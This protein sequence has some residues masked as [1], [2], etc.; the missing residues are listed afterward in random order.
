MSRDGKGDELLY[1]DYVDVEIHKTHEKQT[2]RFPFEGWVRMSRQDKKT[3]Q[4]KA[5][6]GKKNSVVVYPN[7]K[8][9]FEYRIRVSP[10]LNFKTVYTVRIN[11]DLKKQNNYNDYKIEFL[12]EL[13]K[14]GNL[15]LCIHGIY[16]QSEIFKF[17]NDTEPVDIENKSTF[18]IKCKEIGEVSK[19]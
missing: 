3:E 10:Q 7:D 13:P 8:P 18:Q 11:Y 12:S 16:G 15:M 17:N 6:F 1:L 4:L 14:T 2:Y 5:R 9:K 19:N